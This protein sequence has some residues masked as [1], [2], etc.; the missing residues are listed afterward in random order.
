[1]AETIAD[2]VESALIMIVNTTEPGR[3]LKKERKEA[4]LNAVSEI[5][6]CFEEMRT[7]LHAK[8]NEKKCVQKEVS[9]DTNIHKEEDSRE[10]GQV[11]PSVEPAPEAAISN[12]HLLPPSRAKLNEK[13][14]QDKQEEDS[15]A[16]GQVATPVEPALEAAISEQHLLPPSGAKQNKE[17]KQELGNAMMELG[18]TEQKIE[19][20]KKQVLSNM[21]T[22]IQNAM[23]TLSKTLEQQIK[24]EIHN[25]IKRELNQ[26]TS[27]KNTKGKA[28][29]PQTCGQ[30][31]PQTSNRKEGTAVNTLNADREDSTDTREKRQEEKQQE[32]SPMTTE[33]GGRIE[34]NWTEVIRRSRRNST[35]GALRAGSRRAWLYIGRIHDSMT[36]K[37]VTKYLKDGGIEGDIECQEL[38][39]KGRNKAY[40][41]GINF[42]EKE[43]TDKP[44]FWPQNI[45]VRQYRFRNQRTQSATF[46]R[47]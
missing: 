44:E 25:T 24:E 8:E 16:A 36:V 21:T 46:N 1:M 26:H 32:Q 23:D 45:I 35:T 37:D 4:T 34:E 39:T 6:K 41:I 43:K 9:Q 47:Q 11:A 42:E 33:D 3:Y 7:I 27:P 31:N 18:I 2:R 38:T 19:K 22:Q 13:D 28:P 40:K 15:R 20:L 10:T 14:N 17:D 5:R 12:Q 30:R 29:L